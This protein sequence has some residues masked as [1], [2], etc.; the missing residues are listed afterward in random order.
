LGAI[1]GDRCRKGRCGLAIVRRVHG[2]KN[3]PMQ[4]FADFLPIGSKLLVHHECI[5]KA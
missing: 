2:S 1:E 4:A 5:H 3:N